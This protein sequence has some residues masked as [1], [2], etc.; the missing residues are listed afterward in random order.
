MEGEYKSV[1]PL[2][3]QYQILKTALCFIQ[4][5]CSGVFIGDLCI[6]PKIIKNSCKLMDF[7]TAVQAHWSQVLFSRVH[8]NLTVCKWTTAS[9]RM[10]VM[11]VI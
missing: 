6:L 7:V 8:L 9:I 3:L 2:H 4:D 5:N 1:L 11:C 10:Q